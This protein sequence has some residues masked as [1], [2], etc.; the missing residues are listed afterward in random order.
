MYNNLTASLLTEVER[1]AQ[2]QY[3]GEYC[4][5]KQCHVWVGMFGTPY[6]D[7]TRTAIDHS[8]TFIKLNDLLYAMAN[9]PLAFDALKIADRADSIKNLKVTNLETIRNMY[10]ANPTTH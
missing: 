3:K 8:K 7:L 5:F 10:R 2:E 1:I 9:D 6:G 4:F